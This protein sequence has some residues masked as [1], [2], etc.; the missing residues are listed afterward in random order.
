MSGFDPIISLNSHIALLI[1]LKS[2]KEEVAS[3]KGII[4]LAA[5]GIGRLI[6]AELE[7]SRKTMTQNRMW[8]QDKP[9]GERRYQYS[10]QGRRDEY[11]ISQSDLDLHVMMNLERMGRSLK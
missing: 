10:L 5:K 11:E 6:V 7:S 1:M 3:C 4:L 8:V 2:A 9:T